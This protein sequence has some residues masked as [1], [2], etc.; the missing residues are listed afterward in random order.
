MKHMW[1]HTGERP[2][3]F[4]VCVKSFIHMM[5]PARHSA[6]RQHY[7]RRCMIEES[8]ADECGKPSSFDSVEVLER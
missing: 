2:L 3:A 6:S 4:D 7:T 1:L 5:F 8:D